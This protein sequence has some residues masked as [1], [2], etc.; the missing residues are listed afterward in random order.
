MGL[1]SRP[2][3]LHQRS[4]TRKQTQHE[5]KKV[6]QRGEGL[7]IRSHPIHGRQAALHAIAFIELPPIKRHPRISIP[8]AIAQIVEDGACGNECH[9]H[10][11][12][13]D[14]P[15]GVEHPSQLG[16]E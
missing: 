6:E 11:N 13:P 9:R 5:K 2:A 12:R 16:A 14:K 10:G 15:R 7:A 4:S 3:V 1:E 8:F